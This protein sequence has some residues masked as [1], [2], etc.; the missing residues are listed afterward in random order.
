MHLPVT[1]I[2]DVNS[3]QHTL[4]KVLTFA[5]GTMAIKENANLNA[6][7]QL[8]KC[9]TKLRGIKIKSTLNHDP[10]KKYLNEAT[11]V[12]GSSSAS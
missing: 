3:H 9:E 6:A 11:N 12:G 8:R 5:K 1:E 4:K 10:R 2:N 7:S